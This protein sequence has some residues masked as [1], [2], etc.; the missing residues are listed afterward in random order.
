VSMEKKPVVKNKK[1]R[2]ESVAQYIM[3]EIFC[4]TVNIA[5]ISVDSE[6]QYSCND[7]QQ[8]TEDT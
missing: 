3:G 5:S 7:G 2:N 4:G 6:E 8:I 1:K